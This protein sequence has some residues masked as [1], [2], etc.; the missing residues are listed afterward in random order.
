MLH[1][2]EQPKTAAVNTALDFDINA[3]WDHF[4]KKPE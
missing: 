1:A 2:S 3:S 4:F